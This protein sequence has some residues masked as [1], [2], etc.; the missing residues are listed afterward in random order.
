MCFCVVWHFQLLSFPIFFSVTI[1]M[2]FPT[3][4][5]FFCIPISLF[6]PTPHLHHPLQLHRT[7]ASSSSSAALTSNPTPQPNSLSGSE[8][9]RMES[10][11]LFLYSLL[12]S[13]SVSDTFPLLAKVNHFNLSY[14]ILFTY[15]L[16]SLLTKLHFLNS[17]AQR[18]CAN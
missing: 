11:G 17:H 8:S 1:V 14:F 4:P 2:S 10:L 6:P 16:Y 9:K 7:M 3:P 5:E 15:L 12:V 13:F 18:K